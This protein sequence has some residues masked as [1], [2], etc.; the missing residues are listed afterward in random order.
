MRIKAPRLPSSALNTKVCTP[1]L[2][3]ISRS[4]E[5]QLLLS[6]ETLLVPTTSLSISNAGKSV[7]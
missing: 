1:I 5:P 6:R 7:R 3:V 2:L 4:P